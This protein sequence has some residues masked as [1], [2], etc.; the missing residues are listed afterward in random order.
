MGGGDTHGCLTVSPKGR[1]SG[2]TLGLRSEVL[3]RA[4]VSEPLHQC[5]LDN[6]LLWEAVLCIIEC[7]A[8]SL[9]STC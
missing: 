6:S 1:G 5:Y 9:A 4:Q 7:L 8:T 2:L 3:H